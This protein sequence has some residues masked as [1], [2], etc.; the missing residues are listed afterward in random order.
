MLPALTLAGVLD[1]LTFHVIDKPLIVGTE[2][3][4]EGWVDAGLTALRDQLRSWS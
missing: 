1:N 2:S 3:L 4:G